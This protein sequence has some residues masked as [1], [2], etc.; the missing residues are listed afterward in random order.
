MTALPL[1]ERPRP[2][3]PE[4]AGEALN[5]AA[6]Q[7]TLREPLTLFDPALS[8]ATLL[9]ARP[10]VE[11]PGRRIL[12][13]YEIEPRPGAPALV[14]FGKQFADRSHA[15]R[16]HETWAGLEALDLGPDGTVPRLVCLL[17]ELGLVLY[18]PAPG[19]MLAEDLAAPGAGAGVRRTAEWLARL[20]AGALALDRRLD[21]AH[22]V[23]NACI[24]AQRVGQ[25]HPDLADPARRLAGELAASAREIRSEADV[26]IHKDIHAGHVVVG[27]TLAVIDFDEM[28][29]GDPSFDVAHF[30]VYLHLAGIRSG[31][32]GHFRRVRGEFLAEYAARTGW[33]PDEGFSAFW[34]Y[35]CLKVAKQLA[36]GSGIAPRPRG[37]ECIRQLHEMLRCGHEPAG[38][39]R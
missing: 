19:R 5:I 32:P 17:E 1:A 12:I 11:R 2:R 15:G 9:S 25:A 39:R 23:E 4:A 30:C 26:P 7:P 13:E 6:M 28:R 22:E 35:S 37:A 31:R 8:A 14:L 16:L 18:L 29:L 27:D 20:H 38:V 21:V 36:M 33:E 34:A 3:K 24:W 10:V